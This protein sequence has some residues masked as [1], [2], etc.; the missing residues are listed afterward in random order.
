[1]VKELS[2]DNKFNNYIIIANDFLREESY[3]KAYKAFEKALE[4]ANDNNK[5]ID[6][7]FEMADILLIF[8]NYEEA[9][10]LYNKIIDLDKSRSG[11]YY[12]IALVN[13]FVGGSV[14]TS[15]KYYKEAIKWDKN[16]D[17]AYYYLAHAYDK[18]GDKKSA[19][20]NFNKCIEIDNMDFISYNDI[21]SIY[22]ENKDYGKAKE[23]FEKSLSI[24]PKYFRALFNM[25]VVYKDLGNLDKALEY[26]V[27]ATENDQN[28]FIYLNMSAIYIEKKDFLGAIKILNEGILYN[29]DSVNLFYN[30]AC[31]KANLDRNKE[32]I[33]DLKKAIKINKDAFD[34]AKKDPDLLNIVK[35][36]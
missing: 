2:Y 9:R 32:A 10:E 11:A 21:G 1:M 19:L 8:E 33:E 17:R 27:E 34:W 14:N 24:N 25:G 31:S 30:R 35:E 26:Y 7:L 23:Y 16:Y 29:P 22:E 28:P 36:M 4:F 20:E 6:A 12:G 18:I 13:D 15:I 5:K 3:L